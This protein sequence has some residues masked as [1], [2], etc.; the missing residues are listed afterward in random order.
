M[1]TGSSPL[2]PNTVFGIF[3]SISAWVF[4]ETVLTQNLVNTP[5]M[6]WLV[7][8]G[9]L[10]SPA[11]SLGGSICYNDFSNYCSFLLR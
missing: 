11:L 2:L 1:S 3:V 8:G 10:C 5:K 6:A 7:W 9:K 4:E